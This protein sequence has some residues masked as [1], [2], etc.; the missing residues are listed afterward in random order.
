[1]LFGIK[2]QDVFFNSVTILRARQI[3]GLLVGKT[4]AEIPHMV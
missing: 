4:E 2:V 3:Y 1:M